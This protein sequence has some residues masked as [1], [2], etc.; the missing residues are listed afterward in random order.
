[1]KSDHQFSNVVSISE[2]SN[3]SLSNGYFSENIHAT[4]SSFIYNELSD[5]PVRS[6]TDI[7]ILQDN[8]LVLKDMSDRLS[9]LSAE[10]KYLL[11]LK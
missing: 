6:R 3:P 7:E 8:I 1:M 4:S 2:E 10:I 11:N 5:F 9:F